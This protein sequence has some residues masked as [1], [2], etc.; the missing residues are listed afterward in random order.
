MP[1]PSPFPTVCPTFLDRRPLSPVPM[2]I[3]LVV[4]SS[5]VVTVLPPKTL[6][7]PPLRRGKGEKVGPIYVLVV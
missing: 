3:A 4:L 5:S 1:F 6:G 7:T 2:A